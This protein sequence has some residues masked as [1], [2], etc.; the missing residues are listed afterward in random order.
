MDGWYEKRNGTKGME[1]KNKMP[2]ESRAT[3]HTHARY[4]EPIHTNTQHN[5]KHTKPTA[6][7][8]TKMASEHFYLNSLSSVAYTCR[9]QHTLVKSRVY[10]QKHRRVSEKERM[11][12]DTITT[13]II[14]I[15]IITA[16][17][18]ATTRTTTMT[19]TTT[20]TP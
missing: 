5:L 19:A 1:W 9:E 11:G 17:A 14:T 20:R 18:A 7:Q 6:K 10:T 12:R 4:T 8:P 16:A 15:I 3:G 13:I 2:T